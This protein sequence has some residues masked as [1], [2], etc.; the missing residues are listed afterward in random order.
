MFQKNRAEAM[1][2]GLAV[3]LLLT[4]SELLVGKVCLLG[5]ILPVK[6]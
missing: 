4:I 1:Q 3:L 6:N 5:K 2:S